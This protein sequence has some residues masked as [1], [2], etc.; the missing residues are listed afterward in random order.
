M[1]EVFPN[2]FYNFL[3]FFNVK[4]GQKML[5]NLLKTTGIIIFLSSYGAS[6]GGSSDLHREEN[7]DNPKPVVQYLQKPENVSY[8]LGS[9]AILVNKY[10]DMFTP[11]GL[12]AP[13]VK[14][15]ERK[16]ERSVLTASPDTLKQ[17]ITLLEKNL[18]RFHDFQSPIIA[19][20]VHQLDECKKFID[21]PRIYQNNNDPSKIGYHPLLPVELGGKLGGA[22]VPLLQNIEKPSDIKNLVEAMPENNEKERTIKGT[23]KTQIDGGEGLIGSIYASKNYGPILTGL[24]SNE[25]DNTLNDVM[26]FLSYITENYGRKNYYPEFVKNAFETHSTVRIEAQSLNKEFDVGGNDLKKIIFTPPQGDDYS[27]DNYKK[28]GCELSVRIGKM[29]PLQE[30]EEYFKQHYKQSYISRQTYKK[31]YETLTG[32]V[33]K[34]LQMMKKQFPLMRIGGFR[35]AENLEFDPNLP[36]NLYIVV[37]PEISDEL[38]IRFIIGPFK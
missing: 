37:G 14:F 1:D 30:V 6:V 12:T 27:G 32:M 35:E 22:R 15:F 21:N 28:F 38:S 29:K 33:S 24:P 2:L 25:G 20:I 17:Q 9:I 13:K 18:D 8:R 10:W 16:G 4:K 7:K 11:F 34:K 19:N 26:S 31:F 3:V 23:F 36:N 5:S